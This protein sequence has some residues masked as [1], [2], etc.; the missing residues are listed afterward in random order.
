MLQEMGQL[1]RETRALLSLH[2]HCATMGPT[3]ILRESLAS[4]LRL[5]QNTTNLLD[6]TPRGV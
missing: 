1:A 4:L 5:P 6:F 2:F 3:L